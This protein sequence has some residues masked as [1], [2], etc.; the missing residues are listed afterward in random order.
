MVKCSV[1]LA[2]KQQAI[3]KKVLNEKTDKRDKFA[4]QCNSQWAEKFLGKKNSSFI[5]YSPQL[6]STVGVVSEDGERRSG[7]TNVNTVLLKGKK[8]TRTRIQ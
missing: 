8:N 1:I 6:W 5:C 4:M 3:F 7:V 2:R